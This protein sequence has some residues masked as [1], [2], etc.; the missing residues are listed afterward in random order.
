MPLE[1]SNRDARFMAIAA[2][3]L[4]GRRHRDPFRLLQ[5]LS[6]IQ[7]DTISVIA[8]SQELVAFARLGP[9]TRTELSR[10]WWGNGRT[11]EYWA[12]AACVLPL[13]LWPLFAWRRRH[14]RRRYAPTTEQREILARVRDLGE[15]TIADLGGARITP[16][17][18][19]WSPVKRTVEQL[20]A[21]G[22]VVCT[23]RRGFR[24]VY[25][26]TETAVPA[27][28]RAVDLDD[29]ACFAQLAALAAARM[30]VATDDDLADYFRMPIAAMRLAAEAAG[31]LPAVV[32][33]WSRPTWAHPGA[34]NGGARIARHRPV[35][36]SPFDSLIWHRPRTERLFGFRHRLEAY[37]PA[38][39]REHG[40]FVM[41][42]LA[43]GK[44][45][46][47]VDP[48]RDGKVLRAR[49]VSLEPTAVDAMAAA[50][51]TAAHWVG[52]EEVLVE[53]VS[54]GELATP[55]WT[56]LRNPGHTARP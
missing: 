44:L 37:T 36:L 30:G 32:R 21:R 19:E 14:Y 11:F 34:V 40:Y 49:K 2:Q 56:A 38:A 39:N 3:E 18:W 9:V 17:W 13:Q 15:A 23:E 20:L 48:K 33:G 16:G 41:P 28:L 51:T 50:L 31:L 47:R 22:E 7:I 12:H 29:A 54:P 8:R 35:L 26:L 27:E 10:A 24:R 6:A 43:S 4:A 25:R 53:A 55:L 1:L 46:G 5:Q 42:L 52:C 45:R